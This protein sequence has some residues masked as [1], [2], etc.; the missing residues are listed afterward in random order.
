MADEDISPANEPNADR[1]AELERQNAELQR[2]YAASSEE[3]KRL[4][5]LNQQLQ[6]QAFEPTRQAI[7]Q[8]GSPYDRLNETGVDAAA[9]DEIVERRLNEGIQK[10]F[11]PIA[12]GF[13]ARQEMLAEHPDFGKWESDVAAWVHSDE[14]RRSRYESMFAAD[15]MGAN[16]W[17]Y[18]GFGNAQQKNGK[19]SADTSRRASREESAHA[20]IPTERSGESRRRPDDGN[21]LADIRKQMRERGKTPDL[22]DR[23]AKT[24]LGQAIP[25]SHLNQ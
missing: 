8:R 3:G 4:A 2:R 10:A 18:M 23:Y 19:G 11:A 15:P 20:A 5:Q 1:V 13:Q 14:K 22:I 12:K 9:I 21:E 16:E 17:A 24:R 6:Q 25:D 7:P